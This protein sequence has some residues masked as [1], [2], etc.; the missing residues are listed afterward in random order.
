MNF[1]PE[2]TDFTKLEELH[3]PSYDILHG[4]INSCIQNCMRARDEQIKEELKKNGFE[5][6]TQEELERF[7]KARCVIKTQGKLNVLCV[8]DNPICEWWDTVKSEQ[9]GDQF[10]ITLG[11]LPSNCL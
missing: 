1:I 7:A 9:K 2:K 5:F 3:A 8:D 4:V 6:D 11:D 10:T